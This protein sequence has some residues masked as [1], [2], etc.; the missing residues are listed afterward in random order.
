MASLLSTTLDIAV[1]VAPG[2]TGR[3]AFR[4]FIKPLGRSALRPEEADVMGRATIR[5]LGVNGT[6]VTTYRWGDGASPVLLV[7]GWSSRASRFAGFVEALLE[8]G[9]SVVAFDAPG[10]GES[11]GPDATIRDFRDIIRALHDEEGGFT[12]VVAHSIGVLATL[13]ALGEG[14][15]VDRLVAIGGIAHFDYLFDGFRRTVGV[16]PA[17]VRALRD[18]VE[19]RLFADTPDIWHR[20]DARR[21]PGPSPARVLLVHDTDDDM[22]V[23]G[24]PRA[25]AAAFGERARL[26]E[27]R[28]FGHRRILRAPEVIEAAAE[29]LQPAPRARAEAGQTA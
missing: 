5:R 26:V 24:Q 18:H 19:H 9:H 28:G 21:P 7:H 2:P 10:H 23:P 14:I 16:G 4:L 17:V 29:F 6:D 15:P 20:L 25:I 13:F 22:A 12:A 3:A 8:Q 11:P 27:T 1:R